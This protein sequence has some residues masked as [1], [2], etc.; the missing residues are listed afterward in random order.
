MI[1]LNRPLEES[2]RGDDAAL[3][4]KRIYGFFYNS[5]PIPA[6]S[7]CPVLTSQE[8][9]GRKEDKMLGCCFDIMGLFLLN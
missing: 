3:T 2:R 1:H 9:P 5:L 4:S 6:E 8:C 7:L